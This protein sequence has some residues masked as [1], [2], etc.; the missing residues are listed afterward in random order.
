MRRLAFT[1]LA[2]L[3]VSL[4]ASG[5]GK[6]SNSVASDSPYYHG[7]QLFSD[8]C[9]GCHSLD[10]VGA[11]GSSTNVKNKERT[12]GPNFNQRKETK[13]NVLYAIENG[14]FSGAIMPEN[15]LVG[16]DAQDVAAFLAHYSGSAA[17]KTTLGLQQST[18]GVTP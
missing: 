11:Q 7:A 2:L 1:S 4:L 15:I 18:G 10:V 9:A 12:D 13:E 8:H 5:C 3:V 16:Q 17:S 6:Q 14:G